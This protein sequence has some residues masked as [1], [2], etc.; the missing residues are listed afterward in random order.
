MKITPGLL[1]A[2][3][4]CTAD[5]AVLFA[6]LLDEACRAYGIDTPA[7]LAAFLAQVGHESGSFRYTA[8][9]WGPTPQ[10]ER[11]EGRQD[12]GNT[13]AGDGRKFAGHGLIQ[14]TGRFNHRAVRDRLRQRGHDAPDFEAAPQLLAEPR[15]AAWSACDYWDWK[16]CNTLADAG[17]FEALTRKINGGLNG[18]ADRIERWEKAKSALASEVGQPAPAPVSQP[19][20]TPAPQPSDIYGQEHSMPIPIAGIAAA[21]LP[22]LIESIPK[23]G[24]IFGSG[25]EVSERNQAAIGTVLEIVQTATKS[26][27]AQAAVEAVKDNPVARQAAEQALESRWFELVESGGGGIAGAREANAAYAAPGGLQFWL[28]PAFWVSCMLL[29]MVMMLLVDVFYVHPEAY[30]DGLRTQIVTALLLIIGMVGGYWI[31]TSHSSARK[32]ELG[33]GR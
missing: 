6:P 8:E 16:D 20:P 12:L 23:L 25:S 32:T 21:L 1:I 18:L 30:I 4:G 5:R 15:W 11:Y 28:N 24:K 13:Q 7:R 19:A 33:V 22:T 2:A 17:S 9:V 31:G 27:N 26:V 3:V 29:M 10:Q 14:T